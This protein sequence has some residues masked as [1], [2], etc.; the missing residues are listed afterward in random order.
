MR[1]GL[2]SLAVLDV[3]HIAEVA[4]FGWAW[5]SSCQE[6]IAD[7][8]DQN[9]CE[10][11][12]ERKASGLAN[13]KG[14]L[15][16]WKYHSVGVRERYKLGSDSNLWTNSGYRTGGLPKIARVHDVVNVC[17]SKMMRKLSDSNEK[18]GLGPPTHEAV[19]RNMFLNVSQAV[20]RSPESW[21]IT[22]QMQNSHWF[23]MEAQMCLL[24]RHHLRLQGAPSDL[25]LTNVNA[26]AQRSLAGQSFN[27]CSFGPCWVAC[28][29][30]RTRS[31]PQMHLCFLESYRRL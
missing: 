14:P 12:A 27:L 4:L 3:D 1:G 6:L 18:K 16:R 21:G 19:T 28:D 24:A 17:Y 15:A 7:D 26:S 11:R 31:A 2:G 5:G 8:E 10:E 30:V 25:D 22:A 13:N 29:L 23:S 20:Q 9:L